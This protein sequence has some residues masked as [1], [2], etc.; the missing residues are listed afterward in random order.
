MKCTWKECEDEGTKPQLDKNGEEWAV[1]C[2]EH[3]KELDESLDALEPKKLLRAWARAGHGHPSR[4]NFKKEA[5]AGAARLM[6]AF[7]KKV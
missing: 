5:A 4:E 7:T 6:A 2:D 1:L 3:D